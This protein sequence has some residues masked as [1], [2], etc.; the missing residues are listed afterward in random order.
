MALRACALLPLALWL[1]WCGSQARAQDAADPVIE[2][3]FLDAMSRYERRD[4]HQAEALFRRIL[5]RDPS[6]LRVRLELARTL[7][8]ERKDEEA[9]YHL[10]LAAARQPSQLVIRNI[11]RFREA[12]RARRAWRFNFDMGFAPDSNINS[13]TNKESVDVYGLPFQLDP[14]ARARSGTGRFVGGDAS[15]R[16]NRSGRFPIY[17]GAYGRWVR[18]GDHDFDDAYV[19]G[20]AGPELELAG[21]QLRTTATGLMR[22]YGRRPLVSSFGAHLEYEKLVG[23]KWTLGGTLLVR[24]NNYARRRDVDGWDAE[25]RASAN[26]PLGA[27]TLGFAYAGIERS[28]ANDPGQAFWRK[29]LGIGV[30][31]EVGW[32]LRPQL[33]IDLA[34]QVGDGPLA[35]FGKERRDWFLQGNFSIYKRDWNLRGFAPSL[36][37]TVTRNHSTIVLYHEKRL[38]AEIRL[39]RAF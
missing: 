22:W 3:D 35:P 38:R 15:L 26:R 29:R 18:Y 21:G 8:M 1:G 24:H 32:G 34:R 25:L 12:I 31:R 16:L 2:R 13:A 5:D 9:D 14:S 4:Y 11:A 20:E 17:L 30:L 19:G 39:T 37:L 27:T 28:W 7:F 10:R 36:S 23:D 6:L 33:S